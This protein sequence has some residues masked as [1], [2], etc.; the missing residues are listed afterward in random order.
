[1]NISLR[2][3]RSEDIP[4]IIT[5]AAECWAESKIG[6]PPIDPEYMEEN[7]QYILSHPDEACL[8]VVEGK[9]FCVGLISRYLHSPGIFAS[10]PFL[11]ITRSYRGKLGIAKSLLVAYHSWAKSMGVTRITAGGPSEKVSSFYRRHGYMPI[12]GQYLLGSLADIS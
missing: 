9:G 7:I 11:L 6:L 4:W 12:G 8:F 5:L 10:L 2:N 1:M 3:A